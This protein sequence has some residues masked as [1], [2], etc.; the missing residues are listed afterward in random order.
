MQVKSQRLWEKSICSMQPPWHI[1]G[2]QHGEHLERKR[3][4]SRSTKPK[5]ASSFTALSQMF[6]FG[7]FPSETPL[8]S[9]IPCLIVPPSDQYNSHS[10]YHAAAST[11]LSDWI[12]LP[13]TVPQLPFHS[14]RFT[15]FSDTPQWKEHL[16]NLHEVC[17]TTSRKL[18]GFQCSQPAWVAWV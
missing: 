5:E 7:E 18:I 14:Q 10:T 4:N 3:D 11:E 9:S 13:Q 17:S 12:E 2:P 1:T 16:P 8:G 15:F 6:C